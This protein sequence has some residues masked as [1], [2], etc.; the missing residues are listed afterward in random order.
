MSWGAKMTL[1]TKLVGSFLACGLIPLGVIAF[2]SYS[3]AERGMEDITQKGDRALEK[4]AYN[5]LVAL[6]EVKKRQIETYF[7]ERKGDMGVLMETVGTLREE[8]LNKLVSLREVKKKQIEN[9]FSERKGDM[10]V[11]NET[12]NTLRFEAFNKLIAVREIKKRQ[13]ESYFQDRLGLMRDVQKNLRFTKGVPAF[14]QA[15]AQGLESEAYNETY[16]QRIPGLKIFCDI[17][18]FYDVFLIDPQ[19][20]VVFTVAKEADWGTNLVEGPL[21]DSGL[22]RAFEKGKRR[23]TFV[24]YEWY[25]PSNEPGAFLSTPLH[26]DNG[27]LVGV[28][29]FQVSLKEINA[30]MMA[31]DGLGKTGETYLVGQDQLM[32]SD[33]FLDPEHHTVA[34]SFADRTKGSVNTEGSK[35]ACAG[36]TDA[37]VIIDY[38]GNPVLCAWTPVQ[39]GDVT[40]GLL[41]EIDVAEAFAPHIEGAEK[42]FFTQY[43][44]QY[45][46]YDLFLINPDGYCFYTV[47]QE[48]DWKTN[49]VNGK[50]RDSNLGE[51]TRTV[52][53]TKQFGFADFAP[54]APSNGEPAAFIAQPVI[55]NGEVEI[56]V[57]LQLPLDAVNRIMG[58]RAGMGET[59]ETYLIGPDKLMRSDSFLD[60]TNH[61]VKASFANPTKGSVDTEAAN[62][63]LAGKTG[64]NVIMDYNGNP[65]ISAYTPIDVFGTTWGLL[66]EIDVAEAFCPKD[67]N[68]E[69][70]FK[71][72]TEMYGYYDLFLMNPDGYCFYTVA[73][74]SDY[75]TNFVN[76]KY[77]S[78]NLGEVVRK[79]LNT[80]KFGFAD[81]EPYAPSNGEPA[82]FIAQPVTYDGQVEVIVALQLPLDG[83][84]GIM[85]VRAGMGETGETYLIG[86]DK[87]MRSDS[88]LDPT[89]HTVLASF[90]NP[91]TGSVDTDA[92][93]AA[94]KGETDAKIIIDYNGN[95][96]LS[97]YTPIDVFGTRWALLAE[98]D[99]VEAMAAVK[100]MN[101]TADAAGTRLLTLVGS[102]AVV[103]AII[104]LVISLLI[105]RSITRPFK[106]IFRGLKAFSKAELKDTANT[107]NRIIEGMTDSVG[108]V[109]D[110]AGQVSSA[111]QQLAE[112]ASEQASSLEETSSALEQMAAMTRTN[113]ANAKEANELS[114]QS[115]KD[116]DNGSVTMTAIGESSSQISKIIK[117]IEEIAF[118]TNLLALNAAVEAARAGEHGKGFAVVADEVRNLAQRAAQASREITGLIDN[119]VSKAREGSEAIQAIV[120]GVGKVSELINGIARASDEQAQGVD[121][122]NTAISQMDKVTQQNASGAEESASAA[123]E[124]S[125]QAAATK[126]LVDELIVLVRGEENGRSVR[127]AQHADVGH[128]ARK[129][130]DVQVGHLKKAP[131][132]KAQPKP[133]PV[134]ATASSE[135]GSS[136]EFMSL[137]DNS[138]LKDF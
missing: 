17:F 84:N 120:G 130:L 40:W 80:R 87:L 88:F 70:F 129:R 12:V 83:I 15:F 7:G 2:L 136:K 16:D 127:P 30:I 1:G 8:A 48:A 117:V 21:K 119:S 98:I 73:K 89:N 76:G 90:K 95:P 111:S 50:Y 118:Q 33:S 55:H 132:A 56:I 5:Q 79:V 94:L 99:E 133:Q 18:G 29:A 112:G 85:G 116:A 49:L 57:A 101:E 4:N 37:K 82:A 103:A 19:G 106:E 65:V 31:R 100:D 122:V 10:G 60:S 108:Q 128:Q 61:T 35:S 121:Q 109:N 78:S 59:G 75:Q 102:V 41:A 68:G 11:L 58:V 24:D 92:A 124:L 63:A 110:A 66:A 46:Y 51:L 93:S 114:A 38:N 105:T 23:T 77:A 115:H 134:A 74:E 131:P 81:F 62:N 138:N 126:G 113:A 42:D 52:L 107:F 72:Y 135:H 34:A 97:A 54:Y 28:A 39:V 125:A 91:S 43:K 96:V 36:N 20:N 9:Y 3:T 104:V 69:Y 123:E 64:A 53:N 6:R 26:A 22:A 13:I 45:G 47:A 44:E 67:A 86:P 14:M 27:E 137:D 25:E 32:R 71:K